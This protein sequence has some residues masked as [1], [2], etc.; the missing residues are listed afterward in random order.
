MCYSEPCVYL[1]AF[2]KTM[3][4][5]RGDIDEAVL[6]AKVSRGT[7]CM[8]A[9]TNSQF[10]QFLM[11]FATC[12]LLYG[13]FINFRHFPVPGQ[14]CHC[15]TCVYI[16]RIYLYNIFVLFIFKPFRSL[17][18][19]EKLGQNYF[20]KLPLSSTEVMERLRTENVPQKHKMTYSWRVKSQCN[21]CPVHMLTNISAFSLPFSS[22][23]LFGFP[24][25]LILNA[26]L[27]ARTSWHIRLWLLVGTEPTHFITST[28]IKQ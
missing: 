4:M 1:Q 7:K 17:S 9:H 8:N 10:E 16:R 28:T 21:L 6:Y 22:V 2:K 5:S 18:S 23:S 3:A 13:C 24:Y 20:V 12:T 11:C 14:A 26:V 27:M 19:S 15:F 25:S